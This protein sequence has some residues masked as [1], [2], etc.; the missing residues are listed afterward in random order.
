THRARLTGMVNRAL[1]TGTLA[2]L[3]LS[4]CAGGGPGQPPSSG[5]TAGGS[6]GPTSARPAPPTGTT[7]PP[8]TGCDIRQVTVKPGETPPPVCL[9]VGAELQI[10]TPISQRQPWQPFTSSDPQVVA[11]T[12]KYAPAGAAIA[13]CRALRAGTAT[14][15]STT[16]P[17]SGDPHGP[18]QL[19]W[20]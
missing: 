7:P 5:G 19:Y 9:P 12:T 20:E 14:V 4:G 10:T 15:G 16:A 11:C 3:L 1:A 18:P 13:T 6:A 17:F 8:P 2:V